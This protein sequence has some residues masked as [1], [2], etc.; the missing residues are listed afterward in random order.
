MRLLRRATAAMSPFLAC[1]LVT[2]GGACAPD[3]PR[4]RLGALPFPGLT[5]LYK[6]ADPQRLGRHRYGDLPRVFRADEMSRGIVYT[7][8][9]GFLDLAH[10]RITVDQARYCTRAFQRAV[11]HRKDRFELAGPNRS[12]W[13]VALNYPPDWDELSA[14]ERAGLADEM[15]LRAGHQLAYLM[16]TWHELITWFGYRNVILVDERRSAFLHDDV[17]SHVVGL[18]VAERAMRGLPQGASLFG[19]DDAFTAALAAE[20]RDLGAVPPACTDEAAR[21]VEGV[22]WRGGEPLKRQPDVGL[23]SGVVRPWLV[24]G[25]ACAPAAAAGDDADA[26]ATEPEAFPLPR[27]DDVGGRDLSD[28]HSVEIDP[29]ILESG[30]IRAHLPERPP[31]FSGRHDVPRLLEVVAAQMRETIGPAVDQP[32]PAEQAAD[33]RR[34]TGPPA[35]PAAGP[36]ADAPGEVTQ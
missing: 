32:W 17:M 21:A 1:A 10:V 18:R 2:L 12:E 8:R 16:L 24:P 35:A 7:T 25:L 36:A 26:A 30:R 15:S 20:L 34:L 11:K 19:D 23:T 22:W 29:R 9:A 13:L 33:A 31:R 27:L 14:D 5:T 3:A 6:T 4:S 28:F